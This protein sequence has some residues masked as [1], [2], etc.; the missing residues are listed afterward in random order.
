MSISKLNRGFSLIEMIVVVV[1]IAV[2]VRIA[3]AYYSHVFEKARADEAKQRLWEIRVAWSQYAMNNRLPTFSF[4][5][6]DLDP[7]RFPVACRSE[8]YFSYSLNNTNAIATRCT[9]SGKRPQSARAYKVTLHLDNST[10][11]GTPG[12][13]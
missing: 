4:P 11:G 9:H 12:Y 8:N 13:Y 7:V 1:I 3:V 10:W 2:S 5:D 6:L